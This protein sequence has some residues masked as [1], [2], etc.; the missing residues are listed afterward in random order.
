M[1]DKTKVLVDAY[2]G[3]FGKVRIWRHA[4]GS[5]S[6][7]Q[8]D[9]FHS[10][11]DASGVSQFPYIH[12]MRAVLLGRGAKVIASIGGAGCNLATMLAREGARVTAVDL[13]PFAFEAARRHF[14][15]APEVECVVADGRAWL[16]QAAGTFDAI[17]LDVY[18]GGGM[19]GHLFTREFFE[20]ASDR[21]VAGGTLV[22][23]VIIDNHRDPRADIVAAGLEAAGFPVQILDPGG[24]GD[25][26]TLVVAGGM[27]GIRV[28]RGD[29]PRAMRMQ[30]AD[31][32][33]RLP[34]RARCARDDG[35]GLPPLSMTRPRS[36]RSMA[37]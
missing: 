9:A 12:A 25:R 36:A 18:D 30:L 31:M 11:G 3:P 37:G 4:D 33:W 1:T 15:L 8:D 21:L 22:A 2:D 35:P 24:E 34:V 20:L 13:D 6:Y 10:R 16:Q 29:E 32:A 23:N 27:A 7:F 26:N 14:G 5:C 19:P 28:P 17:A